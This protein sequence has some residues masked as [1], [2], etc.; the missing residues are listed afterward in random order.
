M[1]TC[2]PKSEIDPYLKETLQFWAIDVALSLH[3]IL[4]ETFSLQQVRYGI[5]ITHHIS[6]SILVLE[7]Q[8]TQAIVD[9]HVC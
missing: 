1:F 9:P 3:G 4:G 6:L 7:L 8:V 2:R 5:R